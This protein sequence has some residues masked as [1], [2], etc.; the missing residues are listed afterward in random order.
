MVRWFEMDDHELR[1]PLG[2]H[3][4]WHKIPWQNVFVISA[5]Q[6]SELKEHETEVV[7][8]HGSHA[9]ARTV[10]RKVQRRS[11]STYVTELICVAG[12]GKFVHARLPGRAVLA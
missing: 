6:V 9:G 1:L 2:Y 7:E 12:S 11:E 10:E 5:G 3:G 8:Y 4:D